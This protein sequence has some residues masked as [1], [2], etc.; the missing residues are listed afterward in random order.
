MPSCVVKWCRNH[1]D[2]HI[3]SGVTFHLFPQDPTRREQWIKAVQ[4]ERQES[5]WMPTK[6]SKICSIHFKE[7]DFHLSKKKNTMLSKTAVPICTMVFA[8]DKLLSSHASEAK[9]PNIH[10]KPSVDEKPLV[11]TPPVYNSSNTL[12]LNL[13]K[14]ESIPETPSKH[15]VKISCPSCGYHFGIAGNFV[16][17][18]QVIHH[19][20]TSPS[21]NL[22]TEV[23]EIKLYNTPL[24]MLYSDM[25]SA[26]NASK[27][28]S[29]EKKLQRKSLLAKK[30][31]SKIMNLSRRNGRLIE[32]MSILK[33][34]IQEMKNN[35]FKEWS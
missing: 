3:T 11:S 27:M 16:E 31:L 24:N 25:E 13:I 20:R 6:C 23:I 14:K 9:Q 22:T 28:Q 32:K 26:L 17:D 15:K 29:L 34:S 35:K 18:S 33:K 12:Q 4:L 8:S 5:Y 2:H 1:T 10:D 7:T 19:R 30:R 21:L